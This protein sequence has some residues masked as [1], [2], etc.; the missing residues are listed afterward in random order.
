MTSFNPKDLSI[1]VLQ[2]YLQSAVAPRPI[3]FASTIDVHGNPNLSPFS[4]FNVF[5][6]NP[7][8][9]VFS[10]SRRVRDNSPKHTLLNA[11]ATK[12]VVI[13]VVNYDIVQQMSLSSSEYPEGVN[14]FEK[15]GLTMLK[16]DVVKPFRVAESP[17]QF[18]CKVND[19]IKLGTEGGAG[20]LIICE[21]VKF[22]IS[23]DVLNKDE[24]INQKKLD[25][26]A[27]AGGNLYSRANKGFFEV[28]KPL[29]TLGI[30]VDNLPDD[31]KNSMVLTGN[32]LGMLANVEVLPTKKMV[33]E[34]IQ[35]VGERYPNIKS[36]SHREKHKLARNYLSYGDVDSAWKILLS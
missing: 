23:K 1:N 7:P 35:S 33:N 2:S 36:A 30:G 11:E 32:D 20:N 18:E 31:V 24:S 8:I 16:S 27:R 15:A 25:L 13:N 6:A 21:V 4:F 3:A 14:E 12:Q 29:T 9:L 28:P 22:H 17:I 26:V 10:P 34:F 19:I 5:S